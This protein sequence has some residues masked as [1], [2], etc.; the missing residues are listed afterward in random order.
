MTRDTAMT[1]CAIWSVG[2]VSANDWPGRLLCAA[3]ALMWVCV[4]L[5]DKNAP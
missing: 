1:L 3:M 2:I 4:L 5:F